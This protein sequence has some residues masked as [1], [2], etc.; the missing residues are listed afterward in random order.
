MET[1]SIKVA[2]KKATLQNSDFKGVCGNKYTVEFDFDAEWAGH[3]KKTARFIWNNQHLDVEFTGNTCP[4]PVVTGTQMLMVGVFV[5]SDPDAGDVLSSTSTKVPFEVSVRCGNAPSAI[6]VAVSGGYEIVDKVAREGLA[7]VENHAK[8]ITNLE[9]GLAS[10][11]FEVE[12][13]NGYI[14]IKKGQYSR[15]A[16]IAKIGGTIAGASYAGSSN[17]ND[18]ADKAYLIEL[19]DNQHMPVVT[20][21]IPEEIQN[22]DGYGLGFPYNYLD[23]ERKVFVKGADVV[24]DDDDLAFKEIPLTKWDD[25]M[26][27]EVPYEEITDVSHLLGDVDAYVDTDIVEQIWTEW[28]RGDCSWDNGARIEVVFQKKGVI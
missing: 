22:L 1:I 27:E 5:G 26:L 11:R 10:S 16:K 21:N 25:M 23:L 8:R 19:Q 2:N 13:S 15:Y 9:Q 6:E 12:T 24:W 4:A 18:Y 17:P 3:S 14:Y 7:E 28:H 20:I